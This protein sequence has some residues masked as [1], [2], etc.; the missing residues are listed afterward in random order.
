MS[1]SKRRFTQEGRHSRKQR[2]GYRKQYVYIKESNCRIRTEGQGRTFEAVEFSPI[3]VRIRMMRPD[4]S[5]LRSAWSRESTRSC[6]CLGRRLDKHIRPQRRFRLAENIDS[7]NLKLCISRRRAYLYFRKTEMNGLVAYEST[8]EEEA[9]TRKQSP[10]RQVRQN[11][12]VVISSRT[13]DLR[14]YLL[15]P[16]ERNP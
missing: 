6:R 14:N 16:R 5:S 7:N 15:G 12:R 3:L 11:L 13:Q 2:Y 9:N 8:D 10:L 1:L 4:G